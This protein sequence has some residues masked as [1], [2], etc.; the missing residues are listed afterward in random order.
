MTNNAISDAVLWL[1]TAGLALGAIGALILAAFTRVF[2]RI[3]PDGTQSWG[4][5]KGMSNEQWQANNRRLRTM[6]R[7]LFPSAYG[8]IAIG[9]CAQLAALWLGRAC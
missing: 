6:Q 8:C 3:N 5:P 1:N 7:Y 4:T 2:I 9:F